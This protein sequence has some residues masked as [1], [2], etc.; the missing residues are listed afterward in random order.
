MTSPTTTITRV[1][2]RPAR[3][4]PTTEPSAM[5]RGDRQD[6]HAGRQRAVAA[7][8][9]EVLRDQE[10][11]AEQREE[12]HRDRAARGGEGRRAEQA[13]VE[14][15]VRPAPLDRDEDRD[16]C[17]GR[18]R[19]RSDRRGRAPAAVRCLDDRVDQQADAGRRRAAGRAGRVGA[20]V[21]SLDSGTSRNAST[22][23]TSATGTSARNTLPH[24]KCASSTPPVTGP[25]ATPR[26]VTAPQTPIALARSDRDPGTG[27]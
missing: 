24:Q 21:G 11:E 13:H 15:R 6:A 17:G 19:S 23:A 3:R 5:R 20:G 9:L 27:W 16:E 2:I 12:R 22:A 18:E 7:D 10:D 8:E 1:P 14:H 25:T 4:A 26:P